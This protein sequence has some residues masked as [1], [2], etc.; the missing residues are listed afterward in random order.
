MREKLVVTYKDGTTDEAYIQVGSFVITI[1]SYVCY[2]ENGS[3][4]WLQRLEVKK[5]II[6]QE[7]S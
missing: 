6:S 5:A 1:G 4:V 2:L 7:I 3:K